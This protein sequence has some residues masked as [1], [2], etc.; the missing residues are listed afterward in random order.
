MSSDLSMA[1]FP[2]ENDNFEV[3]LSAVVPLYNEAEN[4][5]ELVKALVGAI[6]PLGSYELVL[7]DDGSSDITAQRLR[8]LEE[9]YPVLR[10]VY[11]RRNYGQSAA[12][13]AGFDAARGR[14]IITLDGD[15]QNDPRDIPTL[16]ELV[17]SDQADVACGW[18]VN[19]KDRAVDVKIPSL[20]GNAFIRGLTKVRMHDYG[21]AL[22]VFRSEFAKG[23]TLYGELHRFIPV[24]VSAMGA[25]LKEVP[26]R[27]HARKA[28]VSKYNIT[29]APRVFLDL[30]LMA[31]FQKFAT[32]PI[33]FFGGWGL[34][35][36]GIGVLMLLYL[37]G[38]KLFTGADI[39]GRP[40][41]LL[42]VLGVILGTI[43]VCLGLCA[44][45]IIRVYYEMGNRK[46]YNVRPRR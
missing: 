13:T 6:E 22:R 30:V 29:K 26:I 14:Y 15:L 28:G 9:Q 17:K 3:E 24:L 16:L 36:G 43:L 18:R 1:P 25:R 39:G 27:H 46:I 21:C 33:Q 31:F 38:V 32:R 45:L 12:L 37:V 5:Q 20:I 35:A 40:M 8:E 42:G 10:P 4:V 11:L 2:K 34:L 41:L 44:E 7:V 19:R 23:L